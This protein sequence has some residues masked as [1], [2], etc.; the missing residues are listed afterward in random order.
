MSATTPDREATLRT[1]RQARRGP[2]RRHRLVIGGLLAALAGALAARVLGGDYTVTLPD[3]VRILGGAQIPGASFIVLESKLP[4]AVAGVLVGVA[5]GVAGAV[6]QGVLRN[7]LAS[8]D[9]VGVSAGASAAAVWALVVLHASGPMLTG[10]AVAGALLAA[11][12]VRLAAG[13]GGTVRLVLVGVVVAA[14]MSAVV[15]YL[16]TRADVYDAQLALRW[17]SGSL[18]GVTWAQIRGLAIALVA[19]LP[20]LSLLDRDRRALE[21]GPD[22]ARAIGLGRHT[23]DL[24]LLV[25]VLLVAVAVAVTGPIGFVALLCGPAARALNGGR[26]TLVGAGLTGAVLVVAAD[27][28]AA[29]AVPGVNLPV[30]VVTGAAGAPFLLWLLVNPRTA[31]GSAR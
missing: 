16:F 8:P 24:V 25:A 4:R 14:A 13:A 2:R 10:A 1:L 26:A 22:A 28:L 17:L 27:H 9:V 31:S 11:L 29:Y 21:L 23:S 18:N 30:G 7:P 5:F 15:Q 20:A 12:G 3:L 19:L 6:F